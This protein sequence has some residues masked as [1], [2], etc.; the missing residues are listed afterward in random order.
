MKRELTHIAR[1]WC[2][3]GGKT[4][5]SIGSKCGGVHWLVLS[6]SLA[7]FGFSAA[8]LQAV[9]AMEVVVLRL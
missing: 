9:F 6:F 3:E 8:Q 1:L 7:P 4:N 2:S 5:D